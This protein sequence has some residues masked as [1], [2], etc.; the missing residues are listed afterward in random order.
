MSRATTTV[1]PARSLPN[2][3]ARDTLPQL[4]EEMAGYE[5]PS[6]SLADH[7]IEIGPH[8]HGVAWLVPQIDA[9]AALDREAALRERIEELEEEAENI[10]I[11]MLVQH[12]LG[13]SVGVTISGADLIREL[14]FEDLA[15]GLPE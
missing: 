6:E 2:T 13:E 14:G 12:R 3:R 1:R 10:A 9:Q 4:V 5:A 7:A 15:E 11:G 8:N